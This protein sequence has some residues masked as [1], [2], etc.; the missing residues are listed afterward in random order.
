MLWPSTLIGFTSGA[1]LIIAIGPQNAYVLRQGL[2]R[3]HVLKIVLFCAFSDF[4]LMACGV[5]GLAI[6]SAYI[7]HLAPVMKWGGCLFL[8]CYGILSFKRAASGQYLTEDKHKRTTSLKAIFLQLAAFTYLNPHVY[9]DTVL[10][11]GSIAQTQPA[12]GKLSF[13]IGAASGSFV[14]FF[15]LGYGAKALTPLFKKPGAWRVLDMI[16]G[17]TMCTLAGLLLINF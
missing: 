14:W 6:A 11:L 15:A 12:E 1:S 8:F 17:A 10:L 16:I 7:P 5:Y 13:L 3:E 9:M 2:K 4:L